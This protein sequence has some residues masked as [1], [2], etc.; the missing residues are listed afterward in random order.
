MDNGLKTYNQ[1]YHLILKAIVE[2]IPIAY[3]QWS[4]VNDISSKNYTD[5]LDSV[6]QEVGKH[7]TNNG[8]T[9][10]TKTQTRIEDYL[11]KFEVSPNKSIDEFKLIFFT[12]MTLAQ[13]LKGEG[14]LREAKIVLSSMVYLLNY[15]LFTVGVVRKILT[16]KVL[17]MI[18]RGDLVL[19]TGKVGLYITYKVLFNQKIGKD[20]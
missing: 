9:I 10:Y 18:N 12:S 2:R 14:L 8:S 11:N 7:L 6:I 17:K 20:C 4:F 3:S 19:H 16:T 13:S 15:R 5:N 1:D